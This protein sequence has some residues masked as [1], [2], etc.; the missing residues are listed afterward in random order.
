MKGHPSDGRIDAL[1][2]LLSG[3]SGALLLANVPH[4]RVAGLSRA[5]LVADA[6]AHAVLAAVF[7]AEK[8]QKIV[9][10][11]TSKVSFSPLPRP[12]T[13]PLR[14]TNSSATTE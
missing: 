8:K 14:L 5:A 12:I 4:R 10:K 1:N 9:S 3:E 7:G 13:P 11:N 6:L 2:D